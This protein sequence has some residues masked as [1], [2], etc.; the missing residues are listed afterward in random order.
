M[1]FIVFCWPLYALQIDLE[2]VIKNIFE[3]SIEVE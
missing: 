1:H 3:F 2:A